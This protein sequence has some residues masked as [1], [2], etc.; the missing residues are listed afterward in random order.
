MSEQGDVWYFSR[1]DAELGDKCPRARYHRTIST[2]RGVVKIGSSFELSFGS[3]IHK[4]LEWVLT[5]K[6]SLDDAESY[7][8]QS[9][10]KVV[11]SGEV[12]K[13]IPI[14][15]QDQFDR[16]SQAL[17]G[18]L[19]WA[20]GLYVLPSLR[21]AY[22]VLHAEEQTTYIRDGFAL[23]TVAD[24]ILESKED[25]TLIYPDYKTTAWVNPAWMAQWN[26]SAQLHTTARAIEQVLGR[27][28]E[29]CYVQ[30]L[31]KGQWKNDYQ[32]SPMVWGYYNP[33]LDD[34]KRQ[35]RQKGGGGRID[36]QWLWKHT[37]RKGWVRTAQWQSGMSSRQWIEAMPPDMA[38]SV[39]PRTQPIMIDEELAETWWRQHIIKE[40][41]YRE[42]KTQLHQLDTDTAHT[43]VPADLSIYHRE[44]I[45]DR[46]FPQDFT[47]CT[48]VIG[49]RCDY[50][51]LCH[52]GLDPLGCGIY[53]KRPTYAE[54]L[55]EESAAEEKE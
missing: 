28:V 54:R 5:E 51:A 1:G 10:H 4:A 45:M 31:V 9:I 29:Y 12:P 24:V 53:R 33:E 34:E 37:L 2:G 6:M 15:F 25:Q 36:P 42:A 35:V 19:I 38:R 40:Q 8:R 11:I 50:N 52:E 43:I 49:F 32:Q 16:E 18:G 26:R 23:P 47:Q 17:A 41:V 7:A 46:A 21:T 13:K 39:V 22:N 3:I 27:E 30:A 20:W 14:E 44:R 55:A 48:P